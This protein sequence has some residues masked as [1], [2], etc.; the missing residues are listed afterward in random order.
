MNGY[1]YNTIEAEAEYV[2]DSYLRESDDDAESFG[3]SRGRG[4]GRGSPRPVRPAT[5][6]N[7]FR[8]RPAPGTPTGGGGVTQAQLEAALGRVREQVTANATAIKTVDER[9]RTVISDTQKLQADTRKD[10]TKLRSELKSTQMISALLPL[11]ARPG[12]SIGDSAIGRAA[13]LL[14]LV[15]PDLLGG[16]GSSAAG[17]TPSSSSNLLGNNNLLAIAAIAVAS[18]AF[19]KAE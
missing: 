5:G 19:D 6:G 16:S 2:P 7:L 9:V 1:D 14:H 8:P 15:G 17:A 11:I 4:R 3:E 12:T 18:G 13:P 10:V